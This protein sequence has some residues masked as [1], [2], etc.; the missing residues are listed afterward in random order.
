MASLGLSYITHR[1]YPVVRTMLV[2]DEGAG[3]IRGRS[4]RQLEAQDFV[5]LQDEL[6]GH[7]TPLHTFEPCCP[8]CPL[9]EFNATEVDDGR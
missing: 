5:I 7:W 6:F 4:W 1:G 9:H 8:M 2:H 3:L